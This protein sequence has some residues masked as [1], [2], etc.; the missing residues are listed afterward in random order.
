MRFIAILLVLLGI[1]GIVASTIAF[2]D[3]GI[4]C[5]IGGVGALLSGIAF[6]I[7]AGRLKKLEEPKP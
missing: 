2:G 6:W 5:L 7:T 3:I 4:A 1:C